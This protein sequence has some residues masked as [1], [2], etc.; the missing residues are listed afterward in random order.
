MSVCHLIF[1]IHQPVWPEI[2]AYAHPDWKRPWLWTVVIGRGLVDGQWSLAEALV[3]IGRGLGAEQWSLAEA[4][5]MDS[6]H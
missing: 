1:D 4:F 2:M 3:V 5:V 6:G